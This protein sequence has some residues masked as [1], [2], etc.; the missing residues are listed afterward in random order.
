MTGGLYLDSFGSSCRLFRWRPLDGQS[1]KTLKKPSEMNEC[2][3]FQLFGE[4]SWS[5]LGASWWHLGP[6]APTG[7]WR[8]DVRGPSMGPCTRQEIRLVIIVICLPAWA[9]NSHPDRPTQ[10][11]SRHRGGTIRAPAGTLTDPPSA[12]GGNEAAPT[13][14]QPK[15]RQTHTAHQAATWRQRSGTDGSPSETPT[16]PLNSLVRQVRNP[17]CKHC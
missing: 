2:Y 17:K 4:P 13:R 10:R 12:Q 16:P 7:K 1:Q 6:S 5:S 15:P 8:R 11:T 9:P 3:L 14:H